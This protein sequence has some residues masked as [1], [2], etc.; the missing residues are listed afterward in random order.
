[1][2][3]D[4]RAVTEVDWTG[5]FMLSRGGETPLSDKVTLC[6]MKTD[7]K[8]SGRPVRISLNH[9]WSNY[10]PN[11]RQV[12][13]K[14]ARDPADRAPRARRRVPLLNPTHPESFEAGVT[15]A[16]DPRWE[17]NSPLCH[18]NHVH[19]ERSWLWLMCADM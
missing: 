12:E 14:P 15:D 1:M 9:K 3:H 7:G 18:V 13:L 11:S 16:T 6:Q 19:Y 17:S 8:M 5:T 2:Q 4:S 10:E